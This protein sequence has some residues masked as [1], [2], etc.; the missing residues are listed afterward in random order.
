MKIFRS[1]LFLTFLA[2]TYCY[3]QLKTIT[4]DE[5][6]NGTFTPKSMDVLH[7]MNNGQQY[8]VLNINNNTGSTSVD[9]YDYKTLEKVESLVN[10]LNLYEIDYFTDYTFSDD[11]SKLLL[12]TEV[13]SIYRHSTLGIYFVYDINTKRLTKVADKNIQEPT[14]D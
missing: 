9:I 8:S 3:S 7:S 2:S 1:I 6:C 13:E 4:L 11:E 5:I 12:A 14:C 10:S